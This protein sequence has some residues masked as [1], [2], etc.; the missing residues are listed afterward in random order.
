MYFFFVGKVF[1]K[2]KLQKSDIIEEKTMKLIKTKNSCNN[3]KNCRAM[4]NK[5]LEN[6]TKISIELKKCIEFEIFKIS[7]IYFS[8]NENNFLI[9][10]FIS[11]RNFK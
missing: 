4:N 5:K 1:F 11:Q 8:S 3:S 7:F 2:K 10:D 9:S 6:I